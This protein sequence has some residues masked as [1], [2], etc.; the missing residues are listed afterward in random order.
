MKLAYVDH[1]GH[2]ILVTPA[3]GGT[4]IDL[5]PLL[6]IDD[7]DLPR[8]LADA[9]VLLPRVRA[10]NPTQTPAET[11][12][13]PN[14]V[15]WLPPS[16]RPSKIV[17]VAINNR[18]GSQFAHRPPVEPAYFLT[19]PSALTGHGEPVVV[20]AEYGLTHPEPELAVVLGRR[21]RNVTEAEAHEAIFGYTIIN[22]VTSP[23]LKDRD[24]MELKVPG[25]VAH[26]DWRE[27][28]GDRD[29]SIYLTYHARSKGS[30]TFAPMG[31]WLVTADEV[32]DPMALEVRCYLGDE[33]V[34]VDST[35]NLRFPAATVIAHLSRS[36]TL[37]VG[38]VLHLGT[39]FQVADPERY[40]TVRHLDMSRL[41]GTLAIEIDGIGRLENPI[42]RG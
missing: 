12:I 27:I 1:D 41:E 38:D 36:M 23:A 35:S 33:L 3:P 13:N 6:G 37:E 21:C 14:D 9:D 26:T 18:L 29:N 8:L 4:L 11:R 28:R 22:D 7:L 2:P 31:P 39:A 40:P 30:D 15:R 10:I 16:P 24:S 42:A 25:S 5:G 20:P 34:L 32:P 19:A 17:G